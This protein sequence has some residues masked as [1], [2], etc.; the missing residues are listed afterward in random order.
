MGTGM[1][2]WALLSWF[3]TNESVLSSI[4]T[5]R[6]CGGSSTDTEPVEVKSVCNHVLLGLEQDNVYL[7]GKQTAQ[8][9]ETTQANGDAHRSRL[10]LQEMLAK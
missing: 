9:H 10:H 4:L 3:P 6:V 8:D 7:R 1:P 5:L 2:P